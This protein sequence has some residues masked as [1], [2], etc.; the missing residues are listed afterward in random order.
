MSRGKHIHVLVANTR[1]TITLPGAARKRVLHA[2]LTEKSLVEGNKTQI[3]A[4]IVA[5]DVNLERKAIVATFRMTRVMTSSSKSETERT[6]TRILLLP[7]STISEERTS[8][9]EDTKLRGEPHKH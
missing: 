7:I 6:G 4:S 3:V 9:R 2:K 8:M 5:Q 1:A